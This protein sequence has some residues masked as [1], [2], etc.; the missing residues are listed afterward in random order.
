MRPI[1]VIGTARSG[2]SVVSGLIHLHGVW[3]GKCRPADQR[4]PKGFFE[5]ISINRI[6]RAKG[7]DKKANKHEFRR[8]IQK[9]LR[10]QKYKEGQPWIV[11]HGVIPR[12]D[13]WNVFNPY[14]VIVKRKLTCVA[15]S[16]L[17]SHVVENIEKDMVIL[18]ELQ[19]QREHLVIWPQKLI[20][21]D[22]TQMEQILEIIGITFNPQIAEQFIDPVLWHYRG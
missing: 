5:N 2:T 11:K 20:D 17:S 15:F 14:W 9:V 22:Y 4:N 10:Q 21:R 18:A 1:I 16:Q 3:I 13:L 6:I 7:W 12:W 19:Q 8:L